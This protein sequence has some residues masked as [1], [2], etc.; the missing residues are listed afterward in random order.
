MLKT[1]GGVIAAEAAW[2]LLRALAPT[3]RIGEGWQGP[4]PAALGEPIRPALC[5]VVTRGSRLDARLATRLAT[6]EFRCLVVGDGS[7]PA[8]GHPAI[9][10]RVTDVPLPQM[11]IIGDALLIFERQAGPAMG[12]LT[13]PTISLL[14]NTFDAVWS[15]SAPAAGPPGDLKEVLAQLA[16]GATDRKAQ[17]GANLSARTFSRKVA[18]LMRLLGATSRFQAGAEAARRGW[19]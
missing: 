5:R 18:E 17:R 16:T 10:W 11:C 7:E 9:R 13:L 14:T 15:R 1:T 6:I 2:K 3:L 19:T 12:C 4:I 8:G